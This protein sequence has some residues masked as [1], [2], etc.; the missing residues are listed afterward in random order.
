MLLLVSLSIPIIRPLDLI[1]L[2]VDMGGNI[3]GLQGTVRF[4]V[5]GL[6]LGNTKSS[7]FGIQ[8]ISTGH[9]TNAKLGYSSSLKYAL[10]FYTLESSTV[11]DLALL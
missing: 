6:C 11:F 10:L 3:L 9:C 2:D 5:W 1:Q 4:G 7:L 8:N